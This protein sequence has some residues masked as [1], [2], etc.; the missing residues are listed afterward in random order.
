MC[1]YGKNIRKAIIKALTF[2]SPT[3]K[4]NQNNNRVAIKSSLAQSGVEN[5]QMN[6]HRFEAIELRPLIIQPPNF[7]ASGG[8]QKNPCG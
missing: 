3:K 4:R 6:A 8:T 5:S 1:P 2:Q 7:L